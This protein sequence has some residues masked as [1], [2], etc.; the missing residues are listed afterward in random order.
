[1]RKV[2]LIPSVLSFPTV[3]TLA[4]SSRG[5]DNVLKACFA[6]ACRKQLL[7]PCICMG[8]RPSRDTALFS[9]LSLFSGF[10]LFPWF[11][12]PWRSEH[13]TPPCTTATLF[14]QPLSSTFLLLVPGLPT[15]CC[16]ECSRHP[17]GMCLFLLR[18]ELSLTRPR[19]LVLRFVLE[20][21]LT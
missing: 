2:F 8:F 7:A 12:V 5:G 6:W 4:V 10:L 16:C 15:T 9:F 18:L 19:L 21:A 13:R 1:M 11:A 14:S 17:W 20:L 3:K